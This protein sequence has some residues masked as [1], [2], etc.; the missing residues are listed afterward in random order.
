MHIVIC[1][2]DELIRK[3]LEKLIRDFFSKNNL[4]SPEIALF[5][6]GDALLQDPSEKD[7]V[8]LDIEMPGLDG[9]YVGNQLKDANKNVIIFIVTAF[10]E[11]LDDAMRFQ[12]FRYVPKPIEKHRFFQNMKDAL[13][14]YNT[15]VSKI[16]IETRQGIH[17]LL[18]SE[19]I[20]VEAQARKVI[21]H[22]TTHDYASV[23]NMAYW[24]KQLQAKC[25]FQTHR[26]F[27]VNMAHVCGFSHTLVSFHNSSLQA[28]LTRRKYT[29]FKETYLLYL[30]SMR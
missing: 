22:T 30:E 12:V 14:L 29:A 15:S 23:Q 19:I 4:K 28:Y 20:A 17:I 7:I 21:V 16:P 18:T 5:H 13:H 6:S 8:F 9:I 27:I 26:S 25:F 10:M 3:Q 11:Y 2:D 1:D 24:Q